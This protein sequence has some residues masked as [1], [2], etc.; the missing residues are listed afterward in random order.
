MILDC[1]NAVFVFFI[2]IEK[3]D[4]VDEFVGSPGSI[5]RT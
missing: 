5:G 2:E 3:S 1:I 4:F